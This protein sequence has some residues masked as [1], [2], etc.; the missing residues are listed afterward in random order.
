M[1][2]RIISAIILIPLVI[3]LV[4]KTS[5]L[6]FIS[7]AFLISFIAFSETIF[8]VKKKFEIDVKGTLIASFLSILIYFYFL[9]FYKNNIFLPILFTP[10]FLLLLLSILNLFSKKEVDTIF[11]SILYPFLFYFYIIIFFHFVCY[12]RFSLSPG[13]DNTTGAYF[14]ILWLLI[15]W[16]GDSFAYFGGKLLGKHKLS[17]KISPKKTIEGTFFGLLGGIVAG[18]SMY[19]I[20]PEKFYSFSIL[21][22]LIASVAIQFLGQLGDLIESLIKRYFGVK[23]SSNIIPGHGGVFDRIDSLIFTAP[24]FFIFFQFL[25]F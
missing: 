17:P 25:R 5:P 12:I 18:M 20:F 3:L 21:F 22:I 6:L 15:N 19:I 7:I 4:F 8:M 9:H 11:Y 16:L 13:S 1:L 23:D 24:A 10:F 2:K 14:V